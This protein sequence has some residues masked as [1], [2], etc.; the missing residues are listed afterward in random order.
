[1]LQAFIFVRKKMSHQRKFNHNLY[2]Y[3][4]DNTINA[5]T[6]IECIDIQVAQ[7]TNLA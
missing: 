6:K 7:S 2:T 4:T 1:M 3:I 5:I